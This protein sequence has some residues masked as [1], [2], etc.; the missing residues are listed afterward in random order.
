MGEF[1]YLCQDFVNLI[2]SKLVL[3]LTSPRQTVK[4]DGG[5]HYFNR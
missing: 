3:D 1:H 5:F 4:P 2:L